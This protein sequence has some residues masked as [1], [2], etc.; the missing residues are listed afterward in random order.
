MQVK[1]ILIAARA[2]I[3]NRDNWIQGT[4]AT[5]STGNMHLSPMALAACKFCMLGAVLNVTQIHSSAYP[6]LEALAKH[7]SGHDSWVPA[8]VTRFNDGR[9]HSE[10]LAVFDK[11]IKACDS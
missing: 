5:D 11:A 7:I 10:V 4:N 8:T 9:T 6:A 1:E 2:R 3:E